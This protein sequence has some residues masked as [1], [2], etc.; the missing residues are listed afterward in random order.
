VATNPTHVEAKLASIRTLSLL[1]LEKAPPRRRVSR[2]G[3][4]GEGKAGLSSDGWAL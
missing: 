2:Q 4:E 1:L 3:R